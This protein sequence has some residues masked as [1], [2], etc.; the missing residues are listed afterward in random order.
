MEMGIINSDVERL[1]KDIDDYYRLVCMQA[2]MCHR[3]LPSP[4]RQVVELDDLIQDGICAMIQ[5]WDDFDPAKGTAFSTLLHT[6]LANF[7]GSM[8][9]REWARYQALQDAEVRQNLISSFGAH[10]AEWDIANDDEEDWDLRLLRRLMQASEYLPTISESAQAFVNVLLDPDRLQAAVQASEADTARQ[11]AHAVA[12]AAGIPAKKSW[13]TV[14]E[15]RDL[16]SRLKNLD[17]SP[18]SVH[19]VY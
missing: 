2:A 5:A 11:V 6:Y 14:C 17:D 4:T 12:D 7:Y 1:G 8:V 19:R 3:R 9:F 15:L 10:R 18:R 16:T 13:R